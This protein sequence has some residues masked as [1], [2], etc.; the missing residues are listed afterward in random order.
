MKASL[1][2]TLDYDNN[3][4]HRQ[5][6]YYN[7]SMTKVSQHLKS[8]IKHNLAHTYNPST[9]EVGEDWKFKANPFLHKKCEVRWDSIQPLTHIPE[10]TPSRY[11]P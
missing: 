4:A 9:L 3:R 5:T 11:I 7:F 8:S 2:K 1:L 6:K 10:R